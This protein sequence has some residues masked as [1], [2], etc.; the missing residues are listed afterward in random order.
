MTPRSCL[1]FVLLLPTA[2]GAQEL[3]VSEWLQTPAPPAL[4]V[5]A[6]ETLPQSMLSL[7]PT[8][9]AELVAS[10]TPAPAPLP[11][12]ESGFMVEEVVGSLE[13][14]SGLFASDGAATPPVVLQ[15]VESTNVNPVPEPL[16]TVLGAAVLGTALVRRSRRV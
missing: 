14:G 16:T 1:M 9:G 13:V 7:H 8:M 15:P 6:P 10:P 12:P 2:L 4:S 11:D 5:F 3:A